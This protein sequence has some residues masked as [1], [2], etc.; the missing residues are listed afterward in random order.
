LSGDSDEERR[1]LEA[2]EDIE[3]D[4]WNQGSSRDPRF[5][6][7]TQYLRFSSEEGDREENV[8]NERFGMMSL[9]EMSLG[10]MRLRGMSM[11]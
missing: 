5:D 7:D 1:V 9:G 2:T 8:P 3:F 4:A 10:E 11:R 6:E